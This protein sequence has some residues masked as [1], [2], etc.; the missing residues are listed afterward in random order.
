MPSGPFPVLRDDGDVVL[1]WGD[2]TLNARAR[3]LGFTALVLTDEGTQD[4]RGTLERALGIPV[5]RCGYFD[6]SNLTQAQTAAAHCAPQIAQWVRDGQRV[7]VTC[8]LG[9]NRSALLAARAR[10]LLTGEP[11][12]TIYRDMKQAGPQGFSNNVFRRW[13]QSWPARDVSELAAWQ[14]A[15]IAVGGMVA[16]LLIVRALMW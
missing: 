10:H 15:G 5:L 2:H 6:S 4:P 1:A 11:G 13:V 16:G 9:E 12:A 7:L 3:A 8:W 14:K